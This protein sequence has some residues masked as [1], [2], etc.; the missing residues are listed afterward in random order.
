M[1]KW[2]A[3]VVEH[4]RMIPDSKGRIQRIKSSE[5]RLV[6]SRDG[7]TWIVIRSRADQGLFRVKGPG[8]PDET[9]ERGLRAWL[10]EL[11]GAA[12]VNVMMDRLLAPCKGSVEV[13]EELF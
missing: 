6:I 2:R 4:E 9:R 1:I 13:V 10:A 5:K 8:A 7:E 12:H 11:V 3:Q